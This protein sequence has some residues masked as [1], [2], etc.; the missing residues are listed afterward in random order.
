M[1]YIETILYIYNIVS[2]FQLLDVRALCLS[3]VY[4]L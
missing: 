4:S 3:H 1:N 2:I